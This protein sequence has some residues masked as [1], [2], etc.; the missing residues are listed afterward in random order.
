M[1]RFAT[2]LRGAMALV[3]LALALPAAAQ[4]IQDVTAR[5]LNT[6]PQ[7]NID[8]LMALGA[9]A[10][11]LND[12]RPLLINEYVTPNRND[13]AT[14]KLIRFTAVVLSDPLNSGLRSVVNGIP[15]GIH[16]FVRDIN[17]REQGVEGMGMQ[18]VDETQSG[19][20][21]Q[22]NVGD[23]IEITGLLA[24]FF[25][26]SGVAWQVYPLDADAIDLVDQVDPDDPLLDPV[27]VT[28]DDINRVVAT[29]GTGDGLVQINWANWNSLNMQYVRIQDAQITNS[30]QADAGRPNWAVSTVGQ[31]SR[32]AGYDL[33][34]RFRNDRSGVYPNPPF[35]ARTPQDPFIPPPP[36]AIVSVQGFLVFQGNDPYSI[37]SPIGSIF[38]LV[39][40]G[41]DDFVITTSP[42]IVAPEAPTT[43]PTGDFEVTTIARPGGTN[44]LTAL[45]VSYTFFAADGTE[46]RSGSVAMA[47]TEGEDR[48]S[49]TIPVEPGEDGSFVRYTVTATDSGSLTNTSA[50]R[51]TRVLFG[52][53]RQI[54]DVQATLGEVQ[55]PSPFTGITADVNIQGVVMTDPATSGLIAIQDDPELAPWTGVFLTPNQA[56][57]AGL[58][59]GDRITITRAQ[60]IENFG[61][62]QLTVQAGDFQV[63]GSGEPYDHRVLTTGLLAQDANLAEAYEGM[64][65]RFNDVTIT[66]AN[67]DG[68]SPFG[69]FAF[70]SSDATGQIRG[71]TGTTQASSALPIGHTIFQGGEEL[72]FLQGIWGYSFNNFKLHPEVVADF[73]GFAVSSDP[74]AVA[75]VFQL[76]SPFPNPARG[77]ATFAYTL[78]RDG[79]V[80]LEV[81][82]VV[83]RRV[84][85]VVDG[86]QVAGSQTASLDTRPLASGLYLVRLSAGADVQTVRLSVAR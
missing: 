23:V 84:A 64:A 58:S 54:S 41:D 12:I 56:L 1:T 42:P 81:F 9:S 13:P 77:Q 73:G 65:L 59:R 40:M 72:D 6:I 47:P 74:G 10:N 30:T 22:L 66:A 26:N 79:H 25:G 5:Q 76:A 20:A 24:P 11:Y 69:E 14:H 44:P 4:P 53:V 2:A 55:G 46:G 27:T 36:G 63:T 37:G 7:E 8:A 86:E 82:D 50:P 32:I 80:R 28:T 21:L 49:A 85:V 57:T 45:T 43:I 62:T 33:S 38:A 29:S 39:P 48:F 18:I 51:T 68:T 16:F 71:R 19:R 52:G 3:V 67:A 34:H 17:A 15:G 75:G 78:A 35:N 61:Q 60:I 83:G 70:S 31:D